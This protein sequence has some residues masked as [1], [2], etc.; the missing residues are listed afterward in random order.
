M[1]TVIVT[2]EPFNQLEICFQLAAG[3]SAPNLPSAQVDSVKTNT[4]KKGK[5]KGGKGKKKLKKEDIGTPSDFRHVGHVGW[6]P[7]TGFD[8]SS[9]STI[10]LF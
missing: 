6:N 7:E 9:T 2:N 5:D 10:A 3:I 8:V 1:P 4:T